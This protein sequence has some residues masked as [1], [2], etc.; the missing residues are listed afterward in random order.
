MLELPVDLGVARGDLGRRASASQATNQRAMASKRMR[1]DGVDVGEIGD[2]GED[3]SADLEEPRL[4]R[5]VEGAGP[6]LR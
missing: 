3:A 4:G 2:L 6:F 1:P 5:G